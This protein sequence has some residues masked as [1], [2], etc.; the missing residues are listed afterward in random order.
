MTIAVA[1]SGY[2]GDSETLSVTDDDVA[3]AP[4]SDPVSLQFDFGTTTSPLESG[5]TRVTALTTY[6]ASLGYGWTTNVSQLDRRVGNSLTRDLH[7]RDVGTFV[8]DVANGTY[9]VAL[10]I[11]DSGSAHDQTISLEGVSVGTV[12]TAA[13]QFV[14]RTYT[15]TVNDG[16][17]TIHLDGRGGVDPNMVISGLRVSGSGQTNDPEPTPDL[18]L[19]L[20][21]S[22]ISENAG[23]TTAT[24]TRSGSTTESLVVTLSSS[25]TGEA[26]VP[27]TITIAAGQSSATFSVTGVDDNIVDGAQS[28]TIA[29]A[30]SGYDGDSETLSVTDDDVADAPPSDPVSLQ[31]DFGTTTSPLESGHTRVT[32][33]TTYN[34]SLG[35]GWT[36]NV[37]QLDRRV[38]NSLTRDLH[39][40]DVGTFVIDVANGTYDVALTIGDSGSAHDQTISLEGLSV[41][42]VSTAARQF[43]TRTYTT[44][45]TD[46]QLTIHL[47]GRGGVDPNMVISGL[48][49]SG[50]GQTNDPEPTPDLSLSLS[51]SGISE[52]A[53]GTTATVTRS[54]STTE[55]L[56]VTL[57]S[58]DTGE[59]TVPSIITIAAGQ[60]S[61]TFSVTGVDDNI[62]DGAQ[63]VT[64]AVAASG[65]DGDSETLSVTDDDVA[66][67][68]PSD[69]VSLQFDFGTTT[70]PLESGHTRVTALTTY[71]A[72]LGYGWTTN[73]SQLDRRVG[74][75]LTRDL[76][77]RDV[78]TFV[79]DVA[80]GTYDVALTIGDSGSAHDQT[81]SLEGLSVGTVSTAARQFVT[82]TYTTTVT[83]GQLT[84][85]LDGRG[86]VDPN[87]VISGLRVSGSGQTNDPEPTPDLSLSLSESGISENA[88]GTTATV[89]RSGSTTESLVVT[90]SSS[91]TG[92]AAVPSIITI[93]AGQSSATFSVT[94]VDDNIVDG[95]Q[96]VTIAVAASGYDGDS[97]TLSVTDDDVADA[98]PSDPVSLQFDFGTTTSPLESGHTRVT[99]LTTYNAS[100]GYGWT[101][102]VSQLDRRVGNSLTRDLHYR[103]VGTFVIDVANGTYEV[104][105]TVGDSGAAHDQT[106]SLEG[107]SVDSVTTSAGQFVTR[108]YTASVNDGQLTIHLDGRGGVDPNMVIS[109][110]RVTEIRNEQAATSNLSP[111][112]VDE[113]FGKLGAEF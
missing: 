7:Y 102:N 36:T 108:T 56:V 12:S 3:D 20:S 91:D 106:I 75:S 5:H 37:S 64:I 4:P 63:S 50:S 68:P 110:L 45:V 72:S 61:A 30:A 89:T 31:F 105:L 32:A 27:S 33:L 82:R 57:S 100:L 86:G 74:N 9:E 59:A 67:A 81:I 51:E 46:G 14:T 76:H 104:A 34:A 23:G 99:A 1:A 43:V 22:G 17:L 52:N 98:P 53:G 69:P 80:N 77:Y 55:S 101:T 35:Y 60:S 2:D 18:S 6:N 92:E 85:H 13:R 42:T 79:I 66:D 62:V 49:V 8:I 88:G 29:V 71:N 44:T 65:Y 11:G 19:S 87:M 21:E 83:D 41:G 54:G 112:R 90:L 38:G 39:Y 96:S 24:V 70:S 78:G 15:T 93:A 94:G 113:L 10:T 111:E 84:I 107:V 16:Q 95:A 97:E 47:D 26:T 58:S 73:V 25:D 40:R 103:D 48:R 109:G 28:V